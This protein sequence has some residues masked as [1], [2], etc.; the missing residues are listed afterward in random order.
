M[1]L[2]VLLFLLTLVV[3][4]FGFTMHTLLIAAVATLA[5]W[6]IAVAMRAP[7]SGRRPSTRGHG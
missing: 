2:W 6:I 1:L 5:I 7:R 3:S 4:G